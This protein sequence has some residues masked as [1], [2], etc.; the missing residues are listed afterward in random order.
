VTLIESRPLTQC[1]IDPNRDAMPI[2]LDGDVP[3]V[4]AR[5]RQ[6]LVPKRALHLDE[7][8]SLVSDHAHEAVCGLVSGV[9]RAVR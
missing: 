5:R 3:D 7:R 8:F 4:D 6:V 1:L 2:A 9:L